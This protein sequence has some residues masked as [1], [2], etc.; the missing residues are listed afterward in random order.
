MQH[1]AD[2]N[3]RVV[4]YQSRQLKPAKPNYPVHDKELLVMR[5]ALMKFRVFLLG[6]QTFIIYTDHASLQTVTKS[7]HLSQ[8]MA[9]WL[10]F[11]AGYDFGYIISLD[12]QTL[13]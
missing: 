4:S 2:G 11:F 1:D 8:R 7:P 12:Q 10:S 9:R 5:Y 13:S 3:E 6:E